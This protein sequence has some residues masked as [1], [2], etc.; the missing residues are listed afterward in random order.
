M[1]KNY[2]LGMI[3]AT[4]CSFL[5]GLLPIYWKSLVPISSSVIIIYRIF[6]V[7]V[8]S[9]IISL[10]L[11][12]I[13]KI[14][15][16]LRDKKTA[17][18]FLLAGII[19]TANWSIYIWAVNAGFVIQTS[20]GYYIEPIVVSVFGIVFFKEKITKYNLAAFIFAIVGIAI[21]LIHF[22]QLPTIAILLA[23]TFATYAALKKS[24]N[25]E[26]I[27]SLLYETI[28]FAP[29]ALAVIIYLECIGKGAI[30][31]CEPYQYGL[32]MLTGVATAVPLGLF[33]VGA[34]NLP[35]VTLGVTQYISP[36]IALLLGIYA[37]GE[38]FD[39]VQLIA[40]GVIWLGLI[41][42]TIGE[43]KTLKRSN[44]IEKS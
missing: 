19:I 33:A 15:E 36:T 38:P 22:G 25:V 8:V 29:I 37:F 13:K 16:P 12:G 18:K 9:F 39:G 41:I 5:W 43:Y 23:L 3:A 32:L 44:Q 24:F 34:N 1:Q 21:V 11:Y 20:I 4:S 42:F 17:L 35:L 26:S 2:K 14:K 28:F 40:F 31:T 7:G 6:W 27:L 30:G 10:K